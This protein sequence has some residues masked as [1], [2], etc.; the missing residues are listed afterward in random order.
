M[1]TFIVHTIA[2]CVVHTNI[3]CAHHSI[4][5]G[6]Y[7]HSL[8]TPQHIVWYVQ[9]FIVHTIAYRVV[10]TNIHYA[11]HIIWHCIHK[12]FIVHTIAYCIAHAK[13]SYYTPVYKTWLVLEICHSCVRFLLSVLLISLRRVV[14][15]VWVPQT[16]S[17]ANTNRTWH[18]EHCTHRYTLG[19]HVG[20]QVQSVE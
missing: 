2:Y 4:L 18:S 13:H 1:Q 19:V 9:T 15:G 3:N 10:H 5:R 6:T 20:I 17:I 16:N 8:C 12:T 11:H 14:R 7:K